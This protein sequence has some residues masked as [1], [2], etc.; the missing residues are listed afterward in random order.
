MQFLI[1]I[2]LHQHKAGV[3]VDDAVSFGGGQSRPC[4][5]RLQRK[6]DAECEQHRAEHGDVVFHLVY[7]C[8]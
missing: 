6:A 8:F 7:S 3:R 4:R 5:H 1:H 2:L